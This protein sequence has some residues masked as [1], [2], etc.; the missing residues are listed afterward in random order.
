ML[1]G[2]HVDAPHVAFAD[3]A[4]AGR[5]LIEFMAAAPEDAA[6]VLAL[7]RGGVPVGRVLADAL[8][9]PLRLAMVRKLPIP[10][11]PEMGF[12]AVALD[13]RVNLDRDVIDAFHIGEGE[14]EH[15]VRETHAEVRRRAGDYGATRQPPL[16]GLSAYLVDDGLATGWS[17][18][19]ALEWARDAGAAR[20]VVAVPAAPLGTLERLTGRCDLLVCL[21]AQ[22]PGPF[23]VASY[24]RDF[25]DLSD[26]EVRSLL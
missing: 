2:R 11:S 20:T 13:G 17:M 23:A 15:V 24:Y 5:R 10:S 8:E 21:Y 22:R 26:D 1:I 18:L 16:D 3:R 6:V 7:P 19:A 9:A 14:I 12:G 25:H 4:D